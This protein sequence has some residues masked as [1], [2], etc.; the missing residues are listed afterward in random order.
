MVKILS[1]LSLLMPRIAAKEALSI[2]EQ[3][4]LKKLDS[5]QRMLF[6]VLCN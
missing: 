2:T 6:S 1:Q 3:I 4:V 5:G